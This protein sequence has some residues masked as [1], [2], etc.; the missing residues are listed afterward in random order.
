MHPRKYW[1]I[2]NKNLGS[3]RQISLQQ[4]KYSWKRNSSSSTLFI[5]LHWYIS[6]LY[7]FQQAKL[8]FTLQNEVI[9][10]TS[11]PLQNFLREKA[12]FQSSFP[13]FKLQLMSSRF[14]NAWPFSALDDSVSLLVVAFSLIISIGILPSDS[15]CWKRLIGASVIRLGCPFPRRRPL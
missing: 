1:R 10:L 9:P 12:L 13:L 15:N 3:K 6:L 14:F 8:Q 11:Q 2:I 5:E 4:M 7:S